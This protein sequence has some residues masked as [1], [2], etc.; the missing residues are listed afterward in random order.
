MQTGRAIEQRLQP[1][2]PRTRSPPVNDVA[3]ARRE[4]SVR[5]THSRTALTCGCRQVGDAQSP[6]FAEARSRRWRPQ[7]GRYSLGFPV[8]P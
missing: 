7:L 4:R 2:P 3:P 5:T 6:R 8:N 1:A